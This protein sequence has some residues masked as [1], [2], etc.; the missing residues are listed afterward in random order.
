MCAW[1]SKM[2]SHLPLSYMYI[3]LII[4]IICKYLRAAREISSVVIVLSSWNKVFIIIISSSSSFVDFI[5]V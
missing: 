2:F 4:C 3:S 5:D 1:L